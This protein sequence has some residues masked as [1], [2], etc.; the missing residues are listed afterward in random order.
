M[1]TM[2]LIEQWRTS[3]D[4]EVRALAEDMTMNPHYVG[5]P[6][7]FCDGMVTSPADLIIDM[8]IEVEAIDIPES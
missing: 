8:A 1:A 4:P 2:K 7:R 5:M 3:P 6:E